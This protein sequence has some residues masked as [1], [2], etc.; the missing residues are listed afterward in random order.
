[1]DLNIYKS[2]LTFLYLIELGRLFYQKLIKSI[3]FLM[4]K[5]LKRTNKNNICPN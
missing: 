2:S 1:M 4:I 3:Y 5:G